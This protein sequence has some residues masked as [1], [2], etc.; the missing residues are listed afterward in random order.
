MIARKMPPITLAG[1]PLA[2]IGM[3]QHFRAVFR[4]LAK[5]YV[6]TSI[7]DIYGADRPDPELYAEFSPHH[8]AEIGE[9]INIFCI[10]GDE[11]AAARTHLK[12]RKIGAGYNIVFPMWELPR[13]P[14]VW[15]RELETFDEVWT[16]SEFTRQS[17]AQAVSKPVHVAGLGCE[18]HRMA[19]HSRRKFRIPESS[20]AFLFAYDFLSFQDRKNPFAVIQAFREVVERLPD[21]DIALVVKTNHKS[22]RPDQYDSLIEQLKDVQD[23]VVLIDE[24]LSDAEMKCLLHLCDCFVSL[25]RSEAFGFGIAEAM[26]LSKPVIVT[27]Y[28]GNMEYCDPTSARCVGY[29]LIPVAPNAYPHWQDQQ[30]ADAHVAEAADAMI[31]FLRNPEEG[32]ALGRRANA[33]MKT[34]FSYRAIGLRY[35]NRLDGIV[36]ESS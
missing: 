26:Y 24:T 31:N 34:N 22:R 12:N 25:H 19:L 32:R 4:A 6:S 14:A 11:I 5:V 8:A 16:A 9:G 27:A 17:I 29:D 35:L 28:S 2:P 3:G 15:A 21:A 30:W 7:V 1:H 36:G 13:Y 23:R 18:V 20:Y 10:N 33:Q